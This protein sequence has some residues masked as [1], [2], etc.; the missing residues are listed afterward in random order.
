VDGRVLVGEGRGWVRDNGDVGSSHLV[1]QI[2]GLHIEELAPPS[3][4]GH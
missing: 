2:L 1:Q 4:V 3:Q